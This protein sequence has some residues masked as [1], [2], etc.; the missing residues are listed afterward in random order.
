MVRKDRSCGNDSCG[1]I[2]RGSKSRA[3]SSSY[4]I[5]SGGIQPQQ[6]CKP[7]TLDVTLPDAVGGT[8]TTQNLQY[9]RQGPEEQIVEQ[10]PQATLSPRDAHV[11]SANAAEG[12]T[13]TPSPQ[14]E[15]L[16]PTE[17]IDEQGVE[18][19]Q[20][21]T[22]Q[23]SA[24]SADLA[25][26]DRALACSGGEP[27]TWPEGEQ[28]SAASTNTTVGRG[29]RH[30]AKITA[31]SLVL[32]RKRLRHGVTASPSTASEV[33]DEELSELL[34]LHRFGESVHWPS[35]WSAVKAAAHLAIPRQPG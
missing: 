14:N 25:S 34:D 27:G 21:V 19:A 7:V 20:S 22:T 18:T 3:C 30:R 26:P 29:K 11:S 2:C 31:A 9:E 32:A 6:Q 33:P 35:G 8:T 1:P 23:P 24:N 28:H 5:G 15:A 13:A 10:D 16:R 17:S 12:T 4:R